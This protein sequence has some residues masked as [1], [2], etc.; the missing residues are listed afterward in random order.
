MQN[1]S[2]IPLS[3]RIEPALKQEF[4]EVAKLDNRSASSLAAEL[5]TRYL[6]AR[7]NKELAIQKALEE[8][9]KGEFISHENMRVW[10]A[11]LGSNNELPFPEPDV[12]VDKAPAK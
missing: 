8:A 9:D 5:I 7:K 12:F 3:I 4:D 6:Q 1:M 11:S 2:T 10:F